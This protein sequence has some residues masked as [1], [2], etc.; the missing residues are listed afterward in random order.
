MGSKSTP[1]T[2]TNTNVLGLAQQP[3][4]QGG[5]NAAASNA[6]LLPGSQPLGQDLINQMISYGQN[7]FT[8]T[9]GAAGGVV[10][11]ALDYT[12]QVLSGQFPQNNYPSGPQILGATNIAGAAGSA[13]LDWGQRLS[14]AAYGAPGAVAPYASG[15][16]DLSAAA[17]GAGAGYGGA[18]AGAAG[19]APGTVSPAVAGLYG[20]AGP[21]RSIANP[22]MAGLY[23]NAGM[24]I[25]GNPIY[26]SLRGMASGQ[27]ID[28]SR[29]P[30][31]AGT[32]RAATDPLVAQ[33]QTAVAP[34]TESPFEGA[35]RYG[36]GAWANARG[37]AQD[38]LGRAL[39]G[40]TS[41][42]V[43]NAYNTGLSSTLGAG[44]AL[45]QAYNTGTSNI[46]D[47]LSRAGALGQAGVAQAGNLLQAGGGL[48]LSALQAMMQGLGA[49]GQT[50]NQGYST[51]G[52]LL[53]QGGQL[54]QGGQNALI[55]G[56]TGG[57]GATNQGW[58]TA[59][60]AMG[61]AGGLANAGA[62]NLGSIAQNAPELA[63]W[64]MS[65]LAA[66]YNAGWLPVQN[67]ASIL[68]QPVGGNTSQTTPYYSNTLGQVGSAASG[69]ASLGKLFLGA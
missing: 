31:L 54:T 65:Q 41:S 19:Q 23:G 2:S 34:Q 3:Y 8:N 40:A 18:L 5:W 6:G 50:T 17:G 64:P 63:N 49:A 55:Q 25:P 21:A 67:Y 43:N 42:I 69:L 7:N 38:A 28:P 62:L 37:Q 60:N 14:G 46:T 48:D 22:A 11:N 68:G 26:D 30:A 4:L 53:G 59:A 35:G 52:Q 33:Y 1:S 45:G 27:Y 66:G 58:S 24:A 9:A 61:Q 20:L 56:L 44:Q 32:I 13:G 57:A 29:N 12:R 36:S 39:G 10:P 47:A 15:L 16:Q 51:A